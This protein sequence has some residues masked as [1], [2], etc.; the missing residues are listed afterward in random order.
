MTKKTTKKKTTPKKKQGLTEI[1][2]IVDRSTS[3]RTSGL[4][5]RTIEGF[6][7]FI[8]DQKKEK[9]DAKLSLILFDGGDGF[10]TTPDTTYE[11]IHDGIDIKDVPELNNKN[12]VPK[13]MTALY[14]AIGKTIDGFKER[15]EKAKK[16][17]KSEKVIFLIMTDGEENSSR[18]YDKKTVK[19][20][21]DDHK[22]KDK[23]GF[24]FIGAN[25]DAMHE[26]GMIGVA[27]ASTFQ[28]DNSQV[29]VTNAYVCMSNTVSRVR[30][31]SKTT[32]THSLDSLTV[33][34][35]DNNSDDK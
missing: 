20:M 26:G 33:D 19:K 5:E 12:F 17:E 28:Y 10:G 21:I 29:G 32:Y 25:I 22:E 4:I 1:V 35:E 18:E 9:G 11:I 13:G 23:W 8:A 30:G 3:I 31:M 7:S 6:N 34:K 15:M 14:D 16:S 2:C 27:G 24:V